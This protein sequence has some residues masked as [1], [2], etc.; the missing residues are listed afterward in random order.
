M[1]S[2]AVGKFFDEIVC[3]VPFSPF[4]LLSVGCVTGLE[5]PIGIVVSVALSGCRLVLEQTNG[6]IVYL[7]VCDAPVDDDKQGRVEDKL[8]RQL[9]ETTNIV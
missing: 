4:L 9:H 3:P 1:V 8:V 7:L 6:H 5:A 2:L